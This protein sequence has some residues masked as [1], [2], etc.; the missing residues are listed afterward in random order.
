MR[1]DD[2]TNG[3]KKAGERRDNSDCMKESR[4]SCEE[5]YNHGE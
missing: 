3:K 2:K 5:G 1:R 4:S